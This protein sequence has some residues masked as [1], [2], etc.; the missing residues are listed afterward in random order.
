MSCCCCG[1]RWISLLYKP[2][3]LGS[4]SA[5][6]R[7]YLGSIS[8]EDILVMEVDEADWGGYD[9]VDGGTTASL[10]VLLDR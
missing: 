2:C 3:D 9:A 7:L 4:I 6:S 8:Q 1:G 10:A 5:L